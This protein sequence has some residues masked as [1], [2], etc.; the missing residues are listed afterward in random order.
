MLSEL[1]PVATLATADLERSRK[2]YEGMLGLTEMQES[3]DADSPGGVT[4]KCGNGAI[5]V[6]ESQYAGT[7][8][9]TAVT[10]TATD[11]QFDR[12][13]DRLRHKG[14]NFITFDY[15]GMEWDSGVATM[16]GMRAVWFTDPDG[17]IL[18]IGT[19]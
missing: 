9:A 18:N 3:A 13:V 12:E 10:F 2:F 15:E 16:E 14:V 8:K 1:T 19:M 17:N 7:N 5:F 6:Y 11:D 4:Y